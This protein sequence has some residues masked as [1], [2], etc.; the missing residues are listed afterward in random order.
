MD[1]LAEI[2]DCGF[3]ANHMEELDAACAEHR[4]TTFRNYADLLYVEILKTL[5][6]LRNNVL[7]QLKENARKGIKGGVRIWSYHTCHHQGIDRAIIAGLSERGLHTVLFDDGVPMSVDRIVQNSD[8]LWRL[9]FTFGSRFRVKRVRS[10][11]RCVNY[12]YECHEYEL[13]VE[14]VPE[15]LQ[16]YENEKLVNAYVGVTGRELHE[17]KNVHMTSR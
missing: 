2:N 7:T 4:I 15:G 14:F 1:L 16:A 5:E 17:G 13:R 10:L 11:L 12:E 9:A 8:V 6:I 3:A